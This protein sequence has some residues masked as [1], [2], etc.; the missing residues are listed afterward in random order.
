MRS[1]LSNFIFNKINCHEFVRPVVKIHV[2]THVDLYI[3]ISN[4][5]YPIK[6]FISAR[7]AVLDAT[8]HP[9]KSIYLLLKGPSSFKF[10][11]FFFHYKYLKLLPNFLCPTIIQGPLFIF[12][13]KL[14]MSSRQYTNSFLHRK[15]TKISRTRQITVHIH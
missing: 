4:I 2:C 11:I 6:N 15:N 13:P 9:Q 12:C 5:L 7:L 3:C 8:Y 14:F 10:S 1:K